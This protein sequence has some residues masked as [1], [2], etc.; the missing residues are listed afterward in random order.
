M[1][2]GFNGV[3]VRKTMSALLEAQARKLVF[4]L[5]ALI[6]SFLRPICLRFFNNLLLGRVPSAAEHVCREYRQLC[7][8]L[9]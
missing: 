3:F 5:V 7:M 2:D 9:F 4:R 6:I 1:S 8:L